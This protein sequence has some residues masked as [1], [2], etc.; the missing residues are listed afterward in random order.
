MTEFQEKVYNATRRIPRGE[1]RTYQQIAK[2]IGKPKAYR[3]VATALARNTD[4]NTP[5]H[6]VI[7]SSGRLGGYNGMLGGKEKLLRAE[8]ALR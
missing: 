1:T 3:A 8:G 4:K 2:M 7:L 6:R 5:C